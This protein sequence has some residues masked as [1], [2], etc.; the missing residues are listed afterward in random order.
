MPINEQEPEKARQGGSRRNILY[1]LGI[2][3][4]LAV[5]AMTAVNILGDNAPNTLGTKQDGGSALGL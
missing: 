5:L 2:A 4:V 3:L 1:V